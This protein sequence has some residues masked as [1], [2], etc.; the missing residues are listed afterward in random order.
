MNEETLVIES[1]NGNK[2]AFEKLMLLHGEQ[3][4]RTAFLYTGNREDAL[5]VVQDTVYKAY[6]DLHKLKRNQYFL[7]WVTKI[8]IHTSY[9]ILKKKEITISK[10]DIVA[11]TSVD[12]DQRI[13]LIQA[14]GRLKDKYKDAI[15]L[16]YFLDL[17]ISEIAS[18]MNIPKN[19]VK[20]YLFRGK[21]K[22]KEMLEE[23][24][25]DGKEIFSR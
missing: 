14:V 10:Q 25:Y 6:L 7:T 17:P 18:I 21:K 2:E 22:L 20:T 24:S 8:L 16:F 23:V 9:A 19:T 13:D 15:I 3:L 5:D 12:L 11:Q 1:K 4:Y